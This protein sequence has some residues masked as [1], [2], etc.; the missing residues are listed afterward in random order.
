MFYALC[1]LHDTNAWGELIRNYSWK[2]NWRKQRE[3]LCGHTQPQ[4]NSRL[5][6]CSR[7]L[8]A[9]NRDKLTCEQ[10]D[11]GRCQC[12]HFQDLRCVSRCPSTASHD[13]GGVSRHPIAPRR[14]CLRMHSREATCPGI[15]LSWFYCPGSPT[16]TKITH[17]IGKHL[18]LFPVRILNFLWNSVWKF[19]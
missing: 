2:A 19:W 1:Y 7:G 8:G 14:H 13:T 11:L 15:L 17:S 4:I 5:F 6:Y 16:S 18:K 3:L 9:V 10:G 12:W